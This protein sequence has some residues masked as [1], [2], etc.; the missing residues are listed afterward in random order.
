[1]TMDEARLTGQAMASAAVLRGVPCS[2]VRATA[3]R[4]CEH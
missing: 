2:A 1:M 4:L 3:E